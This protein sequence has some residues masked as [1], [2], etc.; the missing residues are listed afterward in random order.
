[1]AIEPF[2]QGPMTET[3]A[4]ELEKRYRASGRRVSVTESFQPGLKYVQVYLPAL[5]HAPKQS[6]IYQQKIWK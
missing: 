3:E 6:N 1:M 4:R 5:K 2:M